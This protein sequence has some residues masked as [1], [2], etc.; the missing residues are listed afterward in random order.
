MICFYALCVLVLVLRSFLTNTNTT[1]KA[2]TKFK[3][4]RKF[5]LEKSFIFGTK[6]AQ[7]KAYSSIFCRLF[8]W[9][10]NRV[11]LPHLYDLEK[12]IC[13]ELI[14]V[15]NFVCVSEFYRY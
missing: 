14:L 8:L 12:F 5:L 4:V 3:W 15:N 9:A 2:F 11:V 7:N 13:I 10:S 6:L 1:F